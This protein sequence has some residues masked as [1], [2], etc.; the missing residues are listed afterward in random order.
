LVVTVA[1]AVVAPEGTVTVAGTVATLTFELDSATT[2]P[3][4]AAGPVRVMVAVELV[5]PG[6][7]LGLTVTD[8][9]AAV[10]TVSVA[11]LL[12]VPWVASM[13]I[14]V[15]A[16][17]GWVCTVT[18]ALLAPPGMV[19]LAG[20]L[21][22]AGLLLVSVTTAPAGGAAPFRVTLATE[23]LPPYNIF[24]LSVSVARAAGLTVSVALFVVL[25]SVAE[26]TTA[27]VALTPCVLMV[28]VPDDEPAATVM[29]P[30][31]ATEVLLLESATISPPAGTG[32]LRVAVATKL[33]PPI[34]LV[35]LS[36]NETSAMG[37][38]TVRL[39]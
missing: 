25:P 36:V 24:G 27:V 38:W 14:D 6:T 21:A 31:E 5:P 4:A 35:G 33:W 3:A 7:L 11:N 37:A 10:L 29:F 39:A 18:V 13:V 17:T 22:T 8:A 34:T 20:R 28:T 23:L 1:T 30:G 15:S 12:T 32:P 9:R 2:T 19:T 16:A 26:I